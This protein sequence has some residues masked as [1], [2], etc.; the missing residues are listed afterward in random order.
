MCNM[1]HPMCHIEP[2]ASNCPRVAVTKIS[3]GHKFD[4]DVIDTLRVERHAL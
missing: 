4:T 1:V 2:H 3:R